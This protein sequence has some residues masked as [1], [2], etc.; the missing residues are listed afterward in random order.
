MHYASLRCGAPVWNRTKRVI[1][2]D[3]GH[4]ENPRKMS[5]GG[6]KPGEEHR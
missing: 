4:A 2:N 6:L 5:K 3:L 1:P